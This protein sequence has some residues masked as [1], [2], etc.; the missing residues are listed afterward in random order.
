MLDG[1]PELKHEGAPPVSSVEGDGKG[2]QISG[3]GLGG[4]PEPL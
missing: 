1:L 3:A 4:V 2:E